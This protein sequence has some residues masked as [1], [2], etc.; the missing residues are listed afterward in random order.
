MNVDTPD[1]V[2]VAVLLL[3]ILVTSFNLAMAAVQRAG[4]EAAR[5]RDQ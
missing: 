3:V 1:A 5:E 4:D 2:R